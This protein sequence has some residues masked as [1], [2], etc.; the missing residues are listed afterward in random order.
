M[1]RDWLDVVGVVEVTCSRGSLVS[2]MAVPGY[3]PV[4][5]ASLYRPSSRVV[6]LSDRPIISEIAVSPARE[7]L[8]STPAAAIVCVVVPPV[9]Y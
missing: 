3:T 5:H 9:T 7:R 2:H 1:C 8:C 6:A 4:S